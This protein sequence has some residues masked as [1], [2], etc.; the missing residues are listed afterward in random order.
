MEIIFVLNVMLI[1]K[2]VM[3]KFVNFVKVLFMENLEI[4]FFVLLVKMNMKIIYKKIQIK[5]NNILLKI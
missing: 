4:L 5:K 1:V 2:I 3:K